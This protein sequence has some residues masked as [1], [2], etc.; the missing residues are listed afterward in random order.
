MKNLGLHGVEIGEFVQLLIARIAEGSDRQRMEVQQLG[1]RWVELWKDEVLEG[2]G[3][4]RL[5]LKPAI[6]S[7]THKVLRRKRLKDWNS[8]GQILWCS[9]QYLCIHINQYIY[10]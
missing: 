3:H 1:V 2:N 4:H 9:F 8:E 10:W 5:C 6:R 7:S